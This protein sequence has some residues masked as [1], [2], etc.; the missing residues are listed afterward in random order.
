MRAAI[1]KKYILALATLLL[2]AIS[3][4][5]TPEG[6][7]INGVIDKN[8][9]VD[10][11]FIYKNVNSEAIKL[12]KAALVDGKFTL[13]GVIDTIEHIYIGNLDK[14][15]FTTFILE[16]DN[17]NVTLTEEE[18]KVEGGKINTMVL[19]YIND[20]EYVALGDKN[21]ELN[22]KA[23]EEKDEDIKASLIKEI[24]EVQ[25][26]MYTI[27][28]NAL[29]RVIDDKNKPGIARLLALIHCQN[30][31]HYNEQK[32]RDLLTEIEKNL[33]SKYN[34]TIKQYRASLDEIEKAEKMKATV[35]VG[36]S[37]KPVSGV[38]INGKELVLENYISKNKYTLLEFWA[39][40]CSPC[41]A[42]MPILKQAYKKY[43]NK[44]FE[45]YS[46]SIDDKKADWELALKEENTTWV[47]TLKQGKKGTDIITSYSIEGIPASFLINQ[48]GKIVAANEELRGA[49]LEKTLNELLK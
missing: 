13:T 11:V 48:K 30:F 38:D 23:I 15:A 8:L 32:R 5:K 22:M 41:R 24:K 40:W 46:F 19:G 25:R 12:N 3:C 26:K 6:Y 28:D 49:N 20:K 1:L 7:T 21:A 9:G 10:S 16:N 44:G 18:I 4:T 37:F 33:D 34:K 39:S 36:K 17:F 43:K 2:I 31:G 42:E 45:I 35:G 14:D 47:H 27:E 29:Y